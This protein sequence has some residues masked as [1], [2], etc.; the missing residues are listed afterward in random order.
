MF[1][2]DLAESWASGS[3]QHDSLAGNKSL[4]INP[5][6]KLGDWISPSWRTCEHNVNT[7]LMGPIKQ[8]GLE[9]RSE[10]DHLREI[11]FSSCTICVVH[12]ATLWLDMQDASG[13]LEPCN[14]QDLILLSP[15]EI[16]MDANCRMLVSKVKRE[17][18]LGRNLQITRSPWL[19]YCSVCF[20]ARHTNAKL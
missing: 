18:I 10:K 11:W 2:C 8:T 9:P 7:H 6:V 20:R 12:Q 15:G 5:G 4:D 14:S 16:N 13:K 17:V 1:M 3:Q 19:L